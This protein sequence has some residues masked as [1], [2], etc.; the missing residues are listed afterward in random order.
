M[1]TR[2]NEYTVECWIREKLKII[3]CEPYALERMGQER[4]SNTHETIGKTTETIH[5][6]LS[7]LRVAALH[8]N[9]SQDQH[10]RNLSPRTRNAI[11][12]VRT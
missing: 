10:L 3:D 2:H 1:E 4:R 7:V 11:S 8:D 12:Q 6:N 5:P 9:C